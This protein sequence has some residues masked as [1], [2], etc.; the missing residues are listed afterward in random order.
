MVT[1]D[2]DGPEEC[3][4]GDD[5]GDTSVSVPGKNTFDLEFQLLWPLFCFAEIKVWEDLDDELDLDLFNEE[6][7]TSSTTSIPHSSLIMWLIYLI[8][9]IQKKH[10]LPYAAVSLLLKLLSVVFFILGKLHPEHSRHFESVSG[11]S[12]LHEQTLGC[13]KPKL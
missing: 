13:K 3:I 7:D 5:S 1:G 12:T 8:A 6:T 9:Q 2:C 10:Y 11:H 4:R